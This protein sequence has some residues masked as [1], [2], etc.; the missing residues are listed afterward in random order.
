MQLTLPVTGAGTAAEREESL[1]NEKSGAAVD[2]VKFTGRM[3]EYDPYVE[4]RPK[5]AAGNPR[6]PQRNP[7][8]PAG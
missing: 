2:F 7:H 8:E 1:Y 3:T 5:L 4:K 6:D